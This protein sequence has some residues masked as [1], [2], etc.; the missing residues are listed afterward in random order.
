MNK[1]GYGETIAMCDVCNKPLE[2]APATWDGEPTFVGYL[3]CPN[4]P[5]AKVRYEKLGIIHNGMTH[6]I[7]DILQ[8]LND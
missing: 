5:K 6:L 3:S 4:H 1:L 2:K 7:E 8:K